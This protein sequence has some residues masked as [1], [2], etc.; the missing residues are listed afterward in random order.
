MSEKEL[1]EHIFDKVTVGV[2]WVDVGFLV[3]GSFLI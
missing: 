2:G 3:G 1:W